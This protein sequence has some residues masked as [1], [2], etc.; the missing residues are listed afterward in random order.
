[1]PPWASHLLVDL[2]TASSDYVCP[3]PLGAPSACLASF[4]WHVQKTMLFRDWWGSTLS[5]HRR[6]VTAWL[7][8][9]LAVV[10]ATTGLATTAGA[11][12][13][14]AATPNTLDLKVLL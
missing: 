12:A 6:R 14:A 2:A 1:M 5:G 8:S 7:A 10:L 13:A 11:G 3:R 4:F 9:C